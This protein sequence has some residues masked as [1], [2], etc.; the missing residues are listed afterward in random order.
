M[1]G[2]LP[3]QKQ[4]ALHSRNTAG[5]KLDSE[6]EH[7]DIRFYYLLNSLVKMII[8]PKYINIF[9]SFLYYNLVTALVGEAYNFT[10][11]SSAG[12]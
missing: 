2:F 8:N 7:E 10:E 5:C 6:S 4:A 11:A 1:C 12:S 9:F 3:L